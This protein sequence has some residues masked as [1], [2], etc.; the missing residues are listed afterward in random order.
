MKSFHDEQE[1]HSTCRVCRTIGNKACTR[2]TKSI[3]M[4]NKEEFS[5]VA[6]VWHACVK[7]EVECSF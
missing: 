1:E 5:V 3:R 2:C 6:G 4:L 7:K